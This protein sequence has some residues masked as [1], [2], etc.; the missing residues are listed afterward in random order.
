[1]SLGQKVEAKVI[2]VEGLRISL[3][4]K[5][6]QDDP[7]KNVDDKYN[8]GDKVTG[9]VIKVTPFG[10]FVK[11]DEDIH[12][13][14]HLSELPADAQ[15]DPGTVL[16]VGE[17]MEFKIISIE[18]SEHRLGL[19]LNEAKSKSSAKKK[20]KSSVKDKEKED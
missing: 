3:S 7:W 17:T 8:V 13:L 6:L 9:A 11:L 12:G 1:M 18:P 19:S 15:S 14:V 16:K 20:K 5:Q 4:L 2:G 10:G